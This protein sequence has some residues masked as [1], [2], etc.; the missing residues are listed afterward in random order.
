MLE[1]KGFFYALIAAAGFSA[2]ACS[3]SRDVDVTGSVSAPAGTQLTAPI[4]L[5]FRDIVNDSDPPKSVLT[6]KLDAPGDFEQ[7][8]SV[9]GDKVRVFA[10]VDANGDG[11]CSAGELWAETDAPI[12]SDDKVE[13]VS[14]ALAQGTCPAN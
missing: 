7:T 9:A 3:G 12:G 4:S 6:T 5:D 11:A 14:L 8:V 2:L 1:R 10:L 13:P